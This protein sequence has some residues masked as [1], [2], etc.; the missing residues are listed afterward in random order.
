[1]TGYL[2][3]YTDGIAV[4]CQTSEQ[5]QIVIGKVSSNGFCIICESCSVSEKSNRSK[6]IRQA[7][8]APQVQAFFKVSIL[9]DTFSVKSKA[10]TWPIKCS[11]SI[12]DS[13]STLQSLLHRYCASS[14]KSG[15]LYI[16]L[17][18][19]KI[20]IGHFTFGQRCRSFFISEKNHIHLLKLTGR[21]QFIDKFQY[22]N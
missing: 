12:M 4:V 13:A 16:F 2:S 21:N 5:D 18:I 14:N 17:N 1:M 22:A 9:S 19:T 20:F 15:L 6:P 3:G 8:S 10:V 11:F 7:A